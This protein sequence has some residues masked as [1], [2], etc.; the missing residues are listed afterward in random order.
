MSLKRSRSHFHRAHIFVCGTCWWGEN[1]RQRQCV[2]IKVDIFWLWRESTISKPRKIYLLCDKIFFYWLFDDQYDF[3]TFSME[4]Y[5]CKLLNIFMSFSDVVND[6]RRSD[7]V[8]LGE[9]SKLGQ[10][11]KRRCWSLLSGAIFIILQ[12][13]NFAPR[14][15]WIKIHQRDFIHR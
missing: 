3:Y 10:K 5:E 1:E 6:L 11:D 8:L 4:I 7:P 13:L 9:K 2:Q 14:K 15:N 12:Q